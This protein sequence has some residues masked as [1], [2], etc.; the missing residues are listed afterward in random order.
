M[1]AVRLPGV[2]G[3]DV[4]REVR[5][6]AAI[7]IL[8]LTAKT[9]T[10]DR[11]HGLELGAD[12]YVTKPFSPRGV[13]LRV[14]AILRRAAGDA[15]ADQ[16]ASYGGGQLLIDETRHQVT[17]HGQPADLT[18]TEWKL[19][20]TLASVPGRVF[21]RFELVNRAHGYDYEGYERTIDSHV[22]NLRR[23]IDTGPR[24]P[25]LIETV[26]GIGYRL[27][28]THDRTPAEPPATVPDRAAAG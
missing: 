23:K 12:D 2:P 28:V 25:G 6:Q 16:L 9:A 19:L 14:R 24:A 26:T 4:A 10:A 22:S 27:A 7:P 11:V 18:S 8:M 1:T 17:A 15:E 20:L 13:V 3:E 5:T 21:T